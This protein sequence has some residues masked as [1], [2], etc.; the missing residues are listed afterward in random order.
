VRAK[1]R[2]AT[3]CGAIPTACECQ[4]PL[5]SVKT[6]ENLSNPSERGGTRGIGVKV[7]GPPQ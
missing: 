6:G 7:T 1:P 3:S 5:R 4:E 2:A